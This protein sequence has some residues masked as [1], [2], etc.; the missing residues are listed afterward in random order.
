MQQPVVVEM[1]HTA[2]MRQ[3]CYH[4]VLEAMLCAKGPL[5]SK[6]CLRPSFSCLLPALSALC[7]IQMPS[8]QSQSHVEVYRAFIGGCDGG[9]GSPGHC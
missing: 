4:L 1:P 2:C 8:R 6:L 3:A 5:Y 7:H 9:D